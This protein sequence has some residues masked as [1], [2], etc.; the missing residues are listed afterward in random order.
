MAFPGHIPSHECHLE[1]SPDVLLLALFF[2]P[3]YLSCPDYILPWCYLLSGRTMSKGEMLSK[4]PYLAL[5]S[6]FCMLLMVPS[7]YG[8][9]SEGECTDE[10]GYRGQVPDQG[11]IATKHNVF[12]RLPNPRDWFS[13]ISFLS[14]LGFGFGSQQPVYINSHS[15]LWET[16]KSPTVHVHNCQLRRNYKN[17]MEKNLN[18]LF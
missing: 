3:C 18:I 4:Q 14:L 10:G 2:I 9:T 6:G 12:A 5:I 7:D 8:S 1:Q 11:H 15:S 17:K 16:V 13:C